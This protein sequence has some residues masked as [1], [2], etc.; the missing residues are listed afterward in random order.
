MDT[1]RF[2]ISAVA[3]TSNDDF[4]VEIWV[5]EVE[6]TSRG[7]G[8]GMDPH[9]ML[10]P[11]NRFVPNEE[12]T[13]IPAARCS[14]GVYGCGSTDVVI[15]L[16]SNLVH[17]DW[18]IEVPIERRVTFAASAYLD[19]VQRIASDWSWESPARTV[20]RL[21]A[22]RAETEAFSQPGGRLSFGC[23]DW[24]DPS[25]YVLCL[26][27]GNEYQVRLLFDWGAKTPVELANEIIDYLKQ[28]PDRWT[29]GWHAI[30]PNVPKP[31]FFAGQLWS[32]W[33]I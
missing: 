25:R 26:G 9:E 18:K 6:M 11:I 23:T 20:W 8:L 32:R 1:L 17:W 5:N 21:V 13:Q 10:V 30:D 27:F 2:A 33:K 16:D 12:P 31:P 28:P 14:C 7:A 3:E 29:A 22:E 24:T 4:Q 19:E 15:V